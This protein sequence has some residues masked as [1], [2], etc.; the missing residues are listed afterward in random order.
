MKKELL[1]K[2]SVEISQAN[3]LSSWRREMWGVWSLRLQMVD[4]KE[5][6]Y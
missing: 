6:I 4:V 2:K 1:G 3:E 5:I